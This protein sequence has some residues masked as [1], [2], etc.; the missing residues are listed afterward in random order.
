MKEIMKKWRK[1]II[2]MSNERNINEENMKERR[3]KMAYV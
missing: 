1:M 3:K 2:T